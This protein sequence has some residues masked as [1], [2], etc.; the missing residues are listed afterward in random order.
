MN[1]TISRFTYGHKVTLKG[2]CVVCEKYVERT[3][4]TTI[5]RNTKALTC[6]GWRCK[7]ELELRRSR[8]RHRRAKT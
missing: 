5:A 4:T 3:V 8:E 2:N 6:G 7:R 1:T